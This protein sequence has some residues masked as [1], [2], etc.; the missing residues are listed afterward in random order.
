[1]VTILDFFFV[2]LSINWRI[3]GFLLHASQHFFF[4]LNCIKKAFESIHWS[5][6]Y[7]KFLLRTLIIEWLL[8]GVIFYLQIDALFHD[9]DLLFSVVFSSFPF[10][11]TNENISYVHFALAWYRYKL[12]WICDFYESKVKICRIHDTNHPAG[13]LTDRK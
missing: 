6:S 7:K 13:M 1:M 8:L 4:P 2:L 9:F 10:T 12:P 11:F 5:I 3:Y